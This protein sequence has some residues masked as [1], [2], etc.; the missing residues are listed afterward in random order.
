MPLQSLIVIAIKAARHFSS[1]ARALPLK[2]ARNL[3]HHYCFT[4][5]P[6]FIL[7]RQVKRRLPSF[8]H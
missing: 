1:A 8:L 2:S 5:L 6:R 4:G 3:T 7:F